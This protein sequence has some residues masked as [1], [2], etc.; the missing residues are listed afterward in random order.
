MDEDEERPEADREDQLLRIGIQLLARPSQR[1]KEE[2]EAGDHDI[3]EE[4]A[5]REDAADDSHHC[6]RGDTTHPRLPLPVKSNGH[7][8][9]ADR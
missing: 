6:G 3:D 9:L 8:E 1:D 7:E 4:D 2:R 5:L